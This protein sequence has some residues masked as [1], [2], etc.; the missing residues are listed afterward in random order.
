[1]TPKEQSRYDF[2]NDL[3]KGE[4]P[5]VGD[6]D[7]NKYQCLEQSQAFAEDTR[8]IVLYLQK[9]SVSGS[10][11]KR[12]LALKY[13]DLWVREVWKK[14]YL[15][16]LLSKA[17]TIEH[18]DEIFAR[19]NIQGGSSS[20]D[21]RKLVKDEFSHLW[22]PDV[23]PRNR[24]SSK[25]VEE[26]EDEIREREV[27]IEDLKKTADRLTTSLARQSE[28]INELEEE[29]ASLRE[30][31]PSLQ[32]E[33][34]SLSEQLRKA[35]EGDRFPIEVT[36]LRQSLHKGPTQDEYGSHLLFTLKAT[37]SAIKCLVESRSTSPSSSDDPDHTA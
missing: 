37:L 8:L 34:D 36:K 28:V 31:S 22:S 4:I 19:H 2:W 23:S 11:M 25:S 33:L 7:Y 5:P 27:I 18:W 9:E 30:A 26:L 3:S 6:F 16:E 12:D 29:I 1:M 35:E 14:S 32:E 20:C 24:A 21:F 17:V 13:K 10:S 15:K